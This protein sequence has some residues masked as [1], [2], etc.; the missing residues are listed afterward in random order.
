MRFF[1]LSQSIRFSSSLPPS[2]SLTFSH[3]ETDHLRVHLQVCLH[4]S[5]CEYPLRSGVYSQSISVLV[6]LESSYPLICNCDGLFNTSLIIS[7]INTS[8][9]LSINLAS[10]WWNI[11]VERFIYEVE[12]GTKQ[13]HFHMKVEILFKKR[14]TH[15]FGIKKEANGRSEKM[16]IIGKTPFKCMV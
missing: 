16:Q 6:T 10:A 5:P 8:T 11:R 2:L 12:S 7:S 14:N 4:V 13:P 9:Y 1:F 15:M 3:W